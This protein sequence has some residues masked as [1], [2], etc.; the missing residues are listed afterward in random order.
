MDPDFILEEIV[1]YLRRTID[2]GWPRERYKFALELLMKI[3]AC[4]AHS[5]GSIDR[6]VASPA[7]GVL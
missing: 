7:T 4:R 5:E 6:D 1:R 2:D 3:E